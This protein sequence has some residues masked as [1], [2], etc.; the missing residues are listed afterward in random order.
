MTSSTII[1][2]VSGILALCSESWKS[3]EYSSCLVCINVHPTPE[4]WLHFVPS[5]PMVLTLPNAETPYY[6]SSGCADPQL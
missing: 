4:L 1:S 6:G 2:P 3:L 5:M